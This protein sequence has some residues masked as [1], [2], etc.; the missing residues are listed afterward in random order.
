MTVADSL[1]LVTVGL[2]DIPAWYDAGDYGDW[3]TDTLTIFCIQLTFMG[4]VS[5][6]LMNVVTFCPHTASGQAFDPTYYGRR[7]AEGRRWADL[8]SPGCVSEDPVFGGYKVGTGAYPGGAWFDPLG[9]ASDEATFKELQ[10]KE[11]KN[12]RLAMVGLVGVAAQASAT[13]VP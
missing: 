13:K 1:I 9:L 11:I 3:F 12:G 2:I 4:Y 8:I 10:L 5:H 7:W 6:M